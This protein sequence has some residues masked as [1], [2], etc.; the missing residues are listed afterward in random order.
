MKLKLQ[1]KS[2]P[3]VNLTSLIDVVL[4]LLVFFMVSTSFVKESQISINLPF[5]ETK[6]L[7]QKYTENLEIMITEQGTYFVN[8][9]E[10]VNSRPI[11]IRNAIENVT[12]GNNQLPVKI[13]ADANARHQHLVTALDIAGKLG[14]T[15]IT[16]STIS[17]PSIEQ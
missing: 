9:R 10:L 7:D 8:G 6:S 12:E 2:E 14:F 16:I 11:T 1:A 17:D 3:E 13:N 5:A 15:K 4:L